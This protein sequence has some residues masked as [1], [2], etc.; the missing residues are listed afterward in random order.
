MGSPGSGKSYNAPFIRK[1]RGITAE[2]LVISSLLTSEEATKIKQAAGLVGDSLVA[3]LLLEKLLQSE[4]AQG[5][6][7]DGFPRTK[8]QVDCIK[9]LKDK[10]LSL[11]TEY[12]NSQY[13][14]YFRRPVFRVAVLFVDENES[15]E[16]QLKRGREAQLHNEKVR[17]SGIGALTEE[18]PTDYSEEKARNRY[19]VFRD[20]YSTLKEL[21]KFFP[22][23]VINTKAPIQQVRDDIMKEFTYQSSLELASSTYDSISKIPV[24]NEITQHARQNLVRRLDNYETRHS[25][26]F[27]RVIDMIQEEFL[28]R[29]K[30]QSI[31]GEAQIRTKNSIFNQPLA[32]EMVLDVLAERGYHV[33]YH[34]IVSEVPVKVD[35]STGEISCKTTTVLVFNVKFKRSIIRSDDVL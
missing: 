13:G 12:F 8:V 10:M 15:V 27:H 16:R 1:A 18:R 2:E 32:L 34:P 28:P 25:E 14:V 23:S 26:L 29:M 31:S 30:Q 35:L 21:Q 9:M 24:V 20:H 19:A 33:A 6:V 5:V 11:R 22:F 7:V 3:E 17:E 4:Y